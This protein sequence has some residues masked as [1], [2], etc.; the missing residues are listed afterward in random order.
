V[1]I[2][3]DTED[4]RIKLYE[5]KSIEG[6]ASITIRKSKQIFLFDFTIEIYF[7]AYREGHK[8]DN[9]MGRVIL[10][11]FNQDD[12]DIDIGYVCEKKSDLADHVRQKLTGP[13]LKTEILK[14]VKELKQELSS[15]DA[16]EEKIKRDK[17]E[18]EQA[19]K[20][21]KDA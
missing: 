6:S 12:D 17:F 8:D 19:E 20:G 13:L 9:I 10:H 18:R 2:A 11:E 15:I 21:Y 14:A 4:L 16:S 5:M 3:I 7:D 1:K